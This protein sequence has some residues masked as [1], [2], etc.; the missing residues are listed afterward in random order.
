MDRLHGGVL[1]AYTRSQCKTG[2][3]MG[4]LGAA[5]KCSRKQPCNKPAKTSWGEM[6]KTGSGKCRSLLNAG[7]RHAGVSLHFKSYLSIFMM[8]T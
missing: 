4:C 1:N 3:L 6:C 5:F 2:A 7:K 8:Q